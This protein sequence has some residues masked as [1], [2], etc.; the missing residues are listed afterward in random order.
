MGGQRLAEMPYRS[1]MTV[2]DGRVAGEWS[3]DSLEAGPRERGG[4]YLGVVATARDGEVAE[5]LEQR[6]RNRGILILA[7]SM[8]AIRAV[9]NAGRTGRIRTGDWSES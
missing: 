7:D 6:P 8:A 2:R 5:A 1:R 9:K 4:K 3:K